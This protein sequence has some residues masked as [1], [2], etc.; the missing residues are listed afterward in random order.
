[1]LQQTMEEWL[2]L[3]PNFCYQRSLRERAYW[4][5]ALPGQEFSHLPAWVSPAGRG[6]KPL[7]SLILLFSNIMAMALG[8]IGLFPRSGPLLRT[9]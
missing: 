6:F 2:P 8:E 4:P 1:M 5:W 9:A 7:P 3:R